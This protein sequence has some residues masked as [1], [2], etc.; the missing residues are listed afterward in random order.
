MQRRP[1]IA[2][3]EWLDTNQDGALSRD[4]VPKEFWERFDLS[5]KDKNRTLSGGELDTA[6]QSSENMIGGDTG[7]PAN[8]RGQPCGI[9]VQQ[10][11]IGA[12]GIEPVRRQMNLFGCRRVHEADRFE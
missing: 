3:L 12:A 10:H 8:G 2:L 9:D 1:R 5:D 7:F 11:Q 4:E 6:F